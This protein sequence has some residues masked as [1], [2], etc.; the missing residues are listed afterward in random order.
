MTF[1]STSASP[2]VVLSIVALGVFI[3]ALDQTVVVTVLPSI[4]VD[5]KIPIS[6]LDHVAWIITAYLLGYTVAMPVIG[7]LSEV[8]G[9]R[10]VYGA[11]LGVFSIGSVL[12]AM[13]TNLEWAV[14]A[15]LIQ[16][17]GGGATVPIG[18]AIA[19]GV[20][21][22]AQRGWAL[23]VIGAAAEA[24]AMLG[25]AYGGAIV[26][27]WNWRGI[28]WLNLL[29]SAVVFMGIHWL[30]E[31]VRQESSR[32]DYLGGALLIAALTVLSLG[33]SRGSLFAGSSPVP[34]ALIVV[35]LGLVFALVVVERGRDHSLVPPILFRSWGFV[36]ANVTQILVGG[37]LII[38][39]VTVP[40]MANTVMGKQPSE[41][42]FWL[43]RLTVAIPVGAIIGGLLL[44]RL[45]SR[46]VTTVGLLFVVLGLWLVSCW[47]LGVGDPKLTGHLVAS[48]FGFG[49]VVAPL[50]TKALDSVAEDYRSTV[51]ALVVV[52]RMLGMTLGLAALSAWGVEQFQVLTTGLE[53]PLPEPGEVM[54]VYRTRVVEDQ[55]RLNQVGLSLYQNFLRAAAGSAMIGILSA[56]AMG[57]DHR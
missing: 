57:R 5:L 13:S 35:G 45:G 50:T 39:L 34:F 16:A 14:T 28:F 54:E 17:V 8:F 22:H 32:M 18:M 1:S 3:T 44:R 51:A 49:L 7:R 46:Q 41:G 29:Q 52:S 6:R 27:F 2:P 12:V 43:L 23:G 53:L 19:V 37:S 38:A 55:Q 30:P 42:A 56:Q 9:Y 40:L 47:D 33:L 26:E 31:R 24:G 11:S 4:M 36:A 15:R 48:G 21:P 20:M 25:P 10:L